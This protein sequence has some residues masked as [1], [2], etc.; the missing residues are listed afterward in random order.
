MRERDEE[1]HRNKNLCRFRGKQILF[2]KVRDLCHHTGKY[3][4]PGHCIC[5]I[6]VTQKQSNL[7]S[8]VFHKFRNY[9]CHLF[10]KT[11]VDRKN[12]K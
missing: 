7:L 4:G 11:L 5:N 10:F 6:M 3:R 8:F 2:D 9:C 1:E 12:L